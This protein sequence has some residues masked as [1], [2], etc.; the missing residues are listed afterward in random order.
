MKFMKKVRSWILNALATGALLITTP[1]YSNP[2]E[3]LKDSIKVLLSNDVAVCSVVFIS[4]RAA[5]T[6]D[7]CV[8]SSASRLAIRHSSTD[9][10]PVKYVLKDGKRDIATLFFDDT[11]PEQVTVPVASHKEVQGLFFGQR[12]F[13]LGHAGSQHRP[14]LDQLFIMEGRFLGKRNSIMDTDNLSYSTTVPLGMGA[15]GGGLFAYF[16]GSWKLI[17]INAER[18]TLNRAPEGIATPVHF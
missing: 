17:G 10:V 12:V 4:P 9:T 15:S 5:L 1:A 2:F 18:D 6:A 3:S 8:P 11:L 7:H 16:S 14:D 13:S